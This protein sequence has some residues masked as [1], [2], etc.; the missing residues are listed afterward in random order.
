MRDNDIF[1]DENAVAIDY[2]TFYSSADGY[3]LRK[4]TPDRYCA[5]ARFEPYLVA[6]CGRDIFPAEL[7]GTRGDAGF[8][9]KAT[10]GR[11]LFVG[12]PARYRAW[13][14]LNGRKLL[15]HNASFD[16]V[17]TLECIKRG[18]INGLDMASVKWYCTADLTAYL[19]CRRALQAAMEIL[20]DK[21]ISKEVRAGMDGRHVYQLSPKE[22]ED[23]I[24]YGGSDAIECHDLW[25]KFAKDWPEIERKISSVSRE[26][27]IQGFPIDVEYARASLK[28]LTRLVAD[29][30]AD[31]PWYP[32]KPVGS[33]PALKEAV[34]ALGARVP[35]SFAKNDPSF[36][37]WQEDHGD[38]KFVK[39]RADYTSANMHA[40]RVE[41]IL[42]SIDDN[43]R[44]HSGFLYFGAHTGRYTG[45]GADGGKN[46]NMLNMPR[47]PIFKGDP[48]VFGG[49]GVDLR[50]MYVADPGC[51]LVVFDYS[52]IEARFSLWLVDDQESLSALAK[53]GINLYELNA[54]KQNWCKLGCD[55]KH[56]DPKM[57]MLAKKEVLALGYGMGPYKFVQ[58]CEAEK[59][60][61][62]S[63]PKDEWHQPVFVDK[64]F[65]DDGFRLVDM[66]STVD[67]FDSSRFMLHNQARIHKSQ[68]NDP[69]FEQDIGRFLYARKAVLDW[70]HANNRICAL[71][72]WYGK[73][74]ISAANRGAKSVSL[75][76]A[77][78]RVKRW[79]DPVLA[80][81]PKTCY[82]EEGRAFTKVDTVLKCT[83]VR[84]ESSK[85]FTGGNI[86]ENVVQATCRD[87]MAYSFVEI[88]EKHPS[89]RY[90]FNVYDE[91]V[92]SVPKAEVDQALVEIPEIMCRGDYIKNWTQGLPLEVD[93][94]SSDFYTK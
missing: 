9:Q 56:T 39:A 55:L 1:S 86:M 2:E 89:W 92:F 50:R 70:R 94:G 85:F 65:Y 67:L 68:L 93:G 18:I 38:I 52:Q 34:A 14:G 90:M 48:R 13:P 75:T 17:V 29:C 60:E 54:A 62:P 16:E 3:S 42:E 44:V 83:P 73:L 6:I 57:Y 15:A 24:E 25:L 7:E 20:F 82:D 79:F 46:I 69:A 31:I 37:K 27:V 35:K 58:S 49:K 74:F 47:A 5:D 23:L 72:D 26:A 91:I 81:E 11:Q 66:G 8:Y 61:L 36:I 84:G 51:Q 30:E 28:E 77:S 32:E 19:G 12:D 87:I 10:E 21:K 78:G 40:K 45:K 41:G 80:K 88:A 4:M 33:I 53:P 76:L 22:Y 59:L 64:A 43:G 63:I 71:W